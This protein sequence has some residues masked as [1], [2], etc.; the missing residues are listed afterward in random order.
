MVC[1][2]AAE[3][4]LVQKQGEQRGYVVGQGEGSP[5]YTCM[6]LTLVHLHESSFYM[7]IINTILRPKV[8]HLLVII[9]T[10]IFLTTLYSSWL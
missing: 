8:S 9:L 6:K 7:T 4:N 2:I 3:S 5:W 10:Q 1:V